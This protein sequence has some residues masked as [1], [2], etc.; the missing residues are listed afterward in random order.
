VVR[1]DRTEVIWLVAGGVVLAL[2]TAVIA[3]R[4]L[5]RLVRVR[6][7]LKSTGMPVSTKAM[8]WASVAYLVWPVDLLPD[9]VYLDDIGVLLLALRSL[10][11]AASRARTPR[12]PETLRARGPA[13]SAHRD[14]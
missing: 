11:A 1:V 6:R 2:V 10:H 12:P 4:V 7:L 9:P 13:R 5:L 14:L 3:V 8:F